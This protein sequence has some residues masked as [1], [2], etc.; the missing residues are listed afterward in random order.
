MYPLYGSYIWCICFKEELSS[1][2]DV[3]KGLSD[4]GIYCTVVFS[5]IHISVVRQDYLMYL[6]GRCPA[7]WSRSGRWRTSET[8]SRPRSG[9]RHN[10]YKNTYDELN[11]KSYFFFMFAP[12]LESRPP[13]LRLSVYTPV[14]SCFSWKRRVCWNCE[15]CWQDRRSW[16]TIS[17]SST[18]CQTSESG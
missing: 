1:F 3:E 2:F 6:Y 12:S 16:S 18:G 9:S 14:Y 11:Q 17:T 7:A 10:I 13:P 4:V 5:V 15:T 8:R